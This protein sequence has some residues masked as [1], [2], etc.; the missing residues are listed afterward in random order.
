MEVKGCVCYIFTSLFYMPKREDLWNKE[1]FLFYF[2]NF[3][4]FWDNQILL[5]FSDIQMSWHHQMPNWVWN[6][7][8][9]L[10]NNLW[11][12]QPGNEIWPVYVTLEDNFIIIKFYGKCGLEIFNFQRILCK[13]KSKE[14]CT[15]IWGNLDSFFI[16]Y[17]M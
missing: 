14:A 8:P 15:P 6:T 13:K 11:S 10:L 12:K 17:L 16:T 7:K 1:K 4:R 3:F 9:I 2:E 5:K